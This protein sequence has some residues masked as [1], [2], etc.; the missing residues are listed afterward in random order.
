[1]ASLAESYPTL[2]KA[3][4]DQYGQP[5][6]VTGGRSA[7]EAML[8]AALSRSADPARAGAVL[9]KLER[10]G[11]LE[12][13]TL[14]GIEP[15]EMIDALRDAGASLSVRSARLLSRLA[16]WY[17]NVFGNDDQDRDPPAPEMTELRADLAAINGLGPAT[18]D[19][20]LLAMGRPVYPMDLGSYRVMVRHGWIDSATEYDQASDLLSRQAG[21]KSDELA[22][23][24]AWLVQVGRQFCLPRS[25]CCQPCPLRC[26]LPDQG[27]LEPDG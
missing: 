7:F 8:A 24:S 1:M 23:L 19:A 13:R 9:E 2:L 21:G 3:L 16:R 25:P 6:S 17:C 18:A 22:C 4:A 15:A 20:I 14:A 11:L 26:V 27:P 12:P 10:C 5:R